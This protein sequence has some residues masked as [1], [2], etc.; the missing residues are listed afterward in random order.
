MQD[1]AYLLSICIPTYNQPTAVKLLLEQLIAQYSPQI[2]IIIS[3]DSPDSSTEILVRDFQKQIPIRYFHRERGGLDRAV[4]FLT[5]QAQGKYVWWIGD[6]V[7]LPGAI[8]T[9]LSILAENSDISFLWVNS[10]DASNPTRLTVGDYNNHLFWDKNQIMNLD[11]GLLGF[12]TATIFQ[13]DIAMPGL[14]NAKR[15]IGSAF[16]C[17]YIILYVISQRGPYYYLG[18]PCFSSPPKLS[19]E[20]RWYDGIQVFG[21]NLFRIVNEF[22]EVFDRRALRKAVSKNLKMVL[23]AIIVE[24]AM[25][26]KTGFAVSDSKILPMAR[27]Y[28]GYL[29]FYKYFPLILMPVS[30]LNVLYRIFKS[31]RSRFLNLK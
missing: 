1:L 19:G 22:K 15:H 6:D 31:I 18:K 4:I 25:G 21:I 2:E 13:R 12:I 7:P 26:L 16:V 17:M 23:R 8:E 11:I 30:V 10:V 14:T 28:W 3:D 9:I 24:R 20:V 29:E 27:I 5:E